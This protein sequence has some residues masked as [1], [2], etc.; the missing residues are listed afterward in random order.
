[1]SENKKS[2]T[3]YAIIPC[4]NRAELCEFNGEF[5]EEEGMSMGL[6]ITWKNPK[7]A[8]CLGVA[9]NLND[10][11]KYTG[12]VISFVFKKYPN[13]DRLYADGAGPM[14]GWHERGN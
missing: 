6:P 8:I 1:M 11:D 3:R 5:D 14:T 4:E 13:V 10:Y 9:S 7:D 2:K 12:E